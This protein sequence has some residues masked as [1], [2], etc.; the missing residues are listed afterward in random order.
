MRRALAPI[1]RAGVFPSRIPLPERRTRRNSYHDS[2]SRL[3]YA[4]RSRNQCSG[5]PHLSPAK[6][7]RSARERTVNSHHP[8]CWICAQACVRFYLRQPRGVF[9]FGPLWHSLSG[10]GWLFESFTCSLPIPFEIAVTRGSA[11][12]LRFL[13]RSLRTHPKTTCTTESF[14]KSQSLQPENC[15]MSVIHEGKS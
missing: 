5:C 14:E 8:R 1:D 13:L 12:K 3:A 15:R 4:D 2:R 6:Q 11:V 10:P 7:S 9:R